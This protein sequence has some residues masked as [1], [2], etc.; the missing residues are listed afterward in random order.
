LKTPCKSDTTHFPSCQELKESENDFIDFT[1]FKEVA[2]KISE[3]CHTRFKY[4]DSL[5]HK[6]HLFN[7]PMDIEVTSDLQS[8]TFFDRR[9]ESPEDFWKMLSQEKFPKPRNV[10]LEI[11]SLF[12]STYG[13]G[14]AFSTMNI[15]KSRMRNHLDNSPLGLCLM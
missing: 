8:D 12:G 6:L 3:E 7:S 5:K 11:L 4:F 14:A 15:I 13:I 1:E 10:S 9:N 2:Y